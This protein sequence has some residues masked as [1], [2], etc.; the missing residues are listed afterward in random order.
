M[1]TGTM[2]PPLV[3]KAIEHCPL[4]YKHHW[5]PNPC[6]QHLECPSSLPSKNCPG[7]KL[8]NFTFDAAQPFNSSKNPDF[9]LKYFHQYVRFLLRK[10]IGST[11]SQWWCFSFG[12]FLPKRKKP[13]TSRNFMWHFSSL[14]QPLLSRNCQVLLIFLKLIHFEFKKNNSWCFKWRKV[15][16]LNGSATTSPG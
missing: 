4:A 2:K 11:F 15:N 3:E 16:N 13:I 5:Y 8:L 14:S 9:Q 7:L 1:H 6:Q 12:I 10:N